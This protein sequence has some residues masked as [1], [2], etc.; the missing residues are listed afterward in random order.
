MVSSLPATTSAL[1][2]RDA[3]RFFGLTAATALFAPS[4]A[5]AA[6]AG[7]TGSSASGLSLTGSQPGF[8]RFNI[9]AFEAIAFFD[10][11][12]AGPT[13]QLQFWK[14]RG[15]DELGTA[16][17]TAFLPPDQI[18]IPFCVLLVRMGAELVLVDSGSG[19]LFGPIA[20]R[21][22]AQLAAAGVKPE[23]ITAVIL[24]HAHGDH[25]GGL[26][27]PASKSP[28]F[29]NARHFIHRSEY[30]FWTGSSPDLSGLNMPDADKQGFIASAK[31]H[32]AAIKFDQIKAG[33]KLLD[34]L[35]I[36]A[37]PGH[38]PGHI[39][40]L[41]SSGNDQLLHLV[42]T[43][44]HHV[45]SFEHPDWSIAFD[46][47]PATAIE[48]RKRIL[49]RASADRLRV[50]GAHLPF[51]SLGHVRILAKG[52]YEYVIEPSVIA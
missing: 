51:P 7:S 22:P 17:K 25:M 42:D 44:H 21:L 3:L 26:L 18:R 8:Y 10:G 46:A 52:R 6:D 12:M 13:A 48:T 20:G 35:E 19:A 16:L 37:T 32:L 28:V 43:V 2:R 39:S 29:K 30:D 1:S 38:T 15:P 31:T 40:L 34:G 50:F 33:E 47:D 41:F 9:G 49:D 27:D 36:I 4:L 23:Q 14:D 24:T 5:R 45:F 11:G